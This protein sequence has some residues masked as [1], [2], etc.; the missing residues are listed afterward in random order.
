LKH[1]EVR[2]K[3]V[4]PYHPQTND[5]AEMSNREIK[6]I[7]EKTVASSRKDWSMKL[8]DALWAYRIAMKTPVG[9]TPF[10]L[11]YG[12][13]CHLSVEMEHKAYW[14]LK[15]LN[16][17]PS[18]S[19]EKRKLQLQELDEM[20]LTA[21]ESSWRYKEKVK[22]YHDKKL[23]K[24]DFQP[25]QQVLLFNSRFKLFPGKLKSKWSGPFTIKAVK[26]YGA[27]ELM[28]PSSE[29]PLRSWVV[30]GQRLKHY[31]GG[32]VQCLKSVF[33]VHDP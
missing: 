32:E 27:I 19:V 3:I 6:K 2:H 21:Y 20:R 31:L 1:Y 15:F 23:L 22:L 7:L 25:G 29:D 5:Q 26:P 16:F 24:K 33:H 30:N 13:S 9:L 14:A 10:Q 4:S 12:K 18:L 17:D 28:D 11:V 8:D